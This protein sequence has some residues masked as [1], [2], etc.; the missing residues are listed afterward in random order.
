MNQKKKLNPA[1]AALIVIV[2]V[3]IVASAA[4]V[5]NNAN[6]SAETSPATNQTTQTN[7]DTS[8]GGTSGSGSTDTSTYK[9]GTY[10]ATGSY[11][12]P[13]GRE[14]I[15]LTVTIKDGVITDTQLQKNATDRDAKEYQKLF[16]DNYKT[17]VVGKSV[18][19]VSLSRVA[20]SSLTSLGF[21][22][23]LTQIKE[24]AKA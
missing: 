22:N 23:A 21:N 6:K 1:V 24:D 19:E 7:N 13:G 15:G 4:I 20:G 2:L 10:N 5:I 3:G 18:D 17:L 11:V 8:G 12:S 14:S 9:D 16:A